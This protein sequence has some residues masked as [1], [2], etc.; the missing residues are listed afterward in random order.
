VATAQAVQAQAQAHAQAPRSR[1]R[2]GWHKGSELDEEMWPTESFGGVSDEQ[3]WDGMASDKPLATTA[4]TAAAPDPGSRR[5]LPEVVPVRDVDDRGRGDRSASSG[6][7][8]YS[9]PAGRSGP[10]D[11]T[12]IQPV[13]RGPQPIQTGPQ[14]IQT[15]PQ[16]TSVAARS[17]QPA[18]QPQPYQAAQSYQ[19]PTQPSPVAG[20]TGRGGIPTDPRGRARP[21]NGTDVGAGAGAHEDPLTSSAYSLRQPGAVDGRSQS[22]GRSRDLSREQYEAAL[23]QETQTFSLADAQAANGGYP[24]GV[25]PFRQFDSSAGGG[26]GRVPEHRSGGGRSDTSIYDGLRSDAYWS[27]GRPDSPRGAGTTDEYGSPVGH[28]YP[29]RPYSGPAPSPAAPS[30]GDTYGYGYPV[31][32]ADDPRPSN[33]TRGQ[34]RSGANGSRGARHAY[35]A[36]NGRR[37]PYDPRMNGRG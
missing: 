2:V 34:G 15:G 17:Y 33:G 37:S 8:A 13:R 31:S 12:V 24:G 26:N 29:E 35:P 16:P 3:F 32:P 14:P 23:S 1:R 4:R 11:R 18:T 30:Y 6:S 19:P 22:P 7:G 5:R 28:P 9:P 20:Q 36:S 27:G 25:P 21:A 10:A